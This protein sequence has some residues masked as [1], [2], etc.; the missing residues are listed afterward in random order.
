MSFDAATISAIL[1]SLLIFAF[2]L[3]TI[4]NSEKRTEEKLRQVA[5]HSSLLTHSDFARD[6]CKAI[7]KQYPDACPGLDFVLRED[8]KG[9]T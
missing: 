3:T 6:L 7:R 2:L 1:V 8:R 9:C 4:R 5:R